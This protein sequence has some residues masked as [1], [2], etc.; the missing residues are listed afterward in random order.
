[1]K[2]IKYSNECG[3]RTPDTGA[4]GIVNMAWCTCMHRLT[5]NFP[6][7]NPNEFPSFCPLP[8]SEKSNANFIC[9][10]CLNEENFHLNYDYD[11]KKL[12]I[13]NILC[14]ECGRLFEKK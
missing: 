4:N 14:N 13:I 10:D 5:T 9:P 11:K 12:P 2:I 3:Y 8:N 1:M 6:C 7:L